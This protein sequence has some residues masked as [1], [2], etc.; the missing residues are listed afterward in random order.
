MA[1][2]PALAPGRERQGVVHEVQD[3]A[4]G[5]ALGVGHAPPVDVVD[6]EVEQDEVGQLAG[7]LVG[8]VGDGLA[9]PQVAVPGDDAVGDVDPHALDLGVDDLGDPPR[10][11]AGDLAVVGD[12]GLLDLGGAPR[13]LRRVDRGQ[14]VG[15]AELPGERRRDVAD[16]EQ[17]VD[18]V[19][20]DLAARVGLLEGLLGLERGA[21][22]VVEVEPERQRGPAVVE[23]DPDQLAVAQR[24]QHGRSDSANTV[25]V[26]GATVA[27]DEAGGRRRLDLAPRPGRRRRRLGERGL[28]GRGQVAA[29]R[30]RAVDDADRG[31]A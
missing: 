25:P 21:R 26:L 2:A 27:T 10:H 31:S 28:L 20:R 17:P 7:H 29:R 18:P 22:A 12:D 23:L 16:A 24:R 11:L 14:D 9:D 1:L 3:V 8:V 19:G 13:H 15:D 5:R 4:V 30:P 6:Q